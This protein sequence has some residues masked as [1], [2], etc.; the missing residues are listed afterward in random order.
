MSGV[1]VLF[2]RVL[3]V[4]ALYAFLGVALWVLWKQLEQASERV[5]G[6][7]VA[8]IRLE[9]ATSTQPGI[10]L[11]FTQPEVTVG[12]HPRS[13]VPLQ[14]EAV[15]VRHAHL[16]FHHGQW[17]LQDLGSKNGTMLNSQPVLRATVLANGDEIRC[18]EARLSVGLDDGAVHGSA[19]SDGGSHA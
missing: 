1:V 12:R 8:P 3:L 18:G 4:A 15:S 11:A 9:V 19:P 7:R 2:L 17:W 5:S 14:D 16:S 6:R 13:D 10:V